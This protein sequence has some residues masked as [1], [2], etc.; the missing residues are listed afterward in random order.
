MQCPECRFDN[1]EEAKFCNE[2]GCAISA[3]C[4]SCEKM[5]PPGS[6]FCNE[7]G[8]SLSEGIT[9]AVNDTAEGIASQG[10]L[11]NDLN[12]SV[13]D[14]PDSERKCVT[15]M[16]SDLTGYTARMHVRDEYD[17]ATTLFEATSAGG[18]IV[19]GGAAGTISFAISSAQTTLWTWNCAVYDLELT[20]GG[21]VVKTIVEGTITMRDE[22]THD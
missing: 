2:C 6:K 4:P 12:A 17:S 19:L 18:E 13:C 21:G 1:P 16:F 8:S 20:S 14:A 5:N 22:V 3:K 10:E 11:E 7:C 9:S 15:V